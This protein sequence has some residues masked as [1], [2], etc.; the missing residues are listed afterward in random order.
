V[1]DGEREHSTRTQHPRDS[2]DERRGVGDELQRAEGG[3]HHVEGAVGEG[4]LRR[5][6]AQGGNHDSVLLVDASAV[7]QLPAGDVDADGASAAQEHPARAL[8]GTAP[9]LEDVPPGDLTERMDVVLADSL[10][11]P[12]EP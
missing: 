5:G 12:Q 6:G 8:P 10:G 4:E 7:L 9:D 2:G 1:G 3:E 11:A